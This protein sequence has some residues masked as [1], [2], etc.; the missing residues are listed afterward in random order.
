MVSLGSVTPNQSRC[1][2]DCMIVNFSWRSKAFTSVSHFTVS[3]IDSFKVLQ[4]III[5]G[6]KWKTNP[7]STEDLLS[8]TTEQ[9]QFGAGFDGS[10]LEGNHQVHHLLKGVSQCKW[11]KRL[12]PII[13]SAQFLSTT[14][15]NKTVSPFSVLLMF[16]KCIW[17]IKTFLMTSSTTPT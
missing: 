16:I 10:V 13:C 12:Q 15:K 9:I 2:E 14:L 3:K 1:F 7:D 5:Q 8:A 6:L 17:G 4:T 11:D